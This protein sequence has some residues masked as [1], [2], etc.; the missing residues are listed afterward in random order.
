[1]T[2]F[3]SVSYYCN[4]NTARAGSLVFRSSYADIQQLTNFY[5]M[6]EFGIKKTVSSWKLHHAET[7]EVLVG[8]RNS[9]I[10]IEFIIN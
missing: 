8:L 5:Y 9:I 6:M 4:H 3:S 1:M 2:Q 10:I 7:D